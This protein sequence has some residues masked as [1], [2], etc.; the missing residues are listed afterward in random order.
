MNGEEMLLDPNL[1]IREI[2]KGVENSHAFIYPC[3]FLLAS[4]RLICV[5][6]LLMSFSMMIG[7]L[8]K[9]LA[10]SWNPLEMSCSELRADRMMIGRSLVSSDER[11]RL[12]TSNPSMP[13]IMRSSSHRVHFHLLPHRHHA[14][15]G[16]Q[17]CQ[18][19]SHI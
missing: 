9:S 5:V 17:H 7:L 13:G 19:L 16:K 3:S 2:N 15:K 8:M 6:T 12:I 1:N 10:P 14:H 4:C 11:R 18:N